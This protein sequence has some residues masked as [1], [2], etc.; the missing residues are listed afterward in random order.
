MKCTVKWFSSQ[1]IKSNSKSV[2]KW[3]KIKIT[4]HY[5]QVIL[6]QNQKITIVISNQDFKSF[7]TLLVCISTYG[8]CIL[9]TGVT[10]HRAGPNIG[11]VLDKDR[12]DMLQYEH[13]YLKAVQRM[14]LIRTWL[15]WYCR[16]DYP[17]TV[18]SAPQICTSTVE[19]RLKCTVWPAVNTF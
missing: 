5:F 15:D 13:V 17:P 16:C 8:F 11:P 12:V 18:L 14:G 7:P 9:T 2:K 19:K 3:F 1:N 4:D 10:K 6:N